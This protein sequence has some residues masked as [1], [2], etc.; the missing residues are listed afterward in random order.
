VTGAIERRLG[1]KSADLYDRIATLTSLA[2]DLRDDAARRSLAVIGLAALRGDYHDY[3]SGKPLPKG[4][5]VIALRAVP[6]HHPVMVSSVKRLVDDVVRG[7]YADGAAE[8]RRMAD[9][10]APRCERVAVQ[11][12]EV[13][14]VS[15]TTREWRVFAWLYRHCECYGVAPLIREL[16]D[17]L[18]VT[19]LAVVNILKVLEDKGAVVNLGGHRGWLPVRSP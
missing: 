18:E 12:R 17:G 10:V 19:Q 2:I 13:S 4:D 8:A 14:E 1:S 9:A 11:Q 15:L 7:D 3:R 16:A 6:C 5:L